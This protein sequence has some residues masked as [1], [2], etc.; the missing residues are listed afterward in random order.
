M[1]LT[2][3]IEVFQKM[4]ETGLV[5]VFYHPEVETC[6]KVLKASYEGG[7]RVFE[8]VNRGEFA[9][10]IFSVLK[11][12]TISE[13]PGMFLGAGSIVDAPTTALFIQAGADFIVSPLLNEEMAKVCNRRKI[14]WAPGCGSL[15]EINK[16]E[17]LGAELVKLFPAAQVGGPGFVKAVLGPCPWSRIMPTGGVDTSKENLNGWFNAGVSCVGIGSKLFTKELIESENY[18]LLTQKVK[19]IM[20][21]IKNLR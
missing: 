13:L 18:P 5:P 7:I 16:A 6:K 4:E 21:T 14:L 9:H 1:S 17:E 10:E 15:T 11:K 19:N 8:F 3:R 12:Y 2:T 20:E